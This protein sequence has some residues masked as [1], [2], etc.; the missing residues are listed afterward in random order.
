MDMLEDVEVDKIDIT[1]GVLDSVNREDIST[2]LD[3]HFQD[4]STE[5]R[6][7]GQDRCEWC[8]RQRWGALSSHVDRHGVEFWI[9]TH[10]HPKRTMIFLPKEYRPAAGG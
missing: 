10:T 1:S 6:P 2:A 9:L 3:Q 8:L 4:P 7:V 5:T